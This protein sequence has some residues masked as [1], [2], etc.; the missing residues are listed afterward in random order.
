MTNLINLADRSCDQWIQMGSEGMKTPIRAKTV[1]Y[2]VTV[3]GGGMAGIC[4]AVAAA[5]NGA[6]VL[7]VQDRSVLGGN[8]SSEIRVIVHGVTKL[9]SGLPERETGILEEILLLNRFCN[10]QHSFT[11]WDHVL[12][13]FVT[14]EENLTL[15]LNTQAVRSFTEDNKIKSILLWQMSTESLITV[16]AD[17]FIDCSGDGL[18]A[19]T[20]GALYRTGR[21]GQDEFGEKYAPKEPDGWQMGATILLSSRDMGK[22]MD[23]KAPPFAIP[24]DAESTHPDRRIIPFVEG[25]WWVEVGSKDDIIGTAET[26]MHRLMGY[27]Y[28]VWDHVKNSG[29]YPEADNFALDWVGSLPGRRESRRFI[30]DYILSEPD[31]LNLKQFDD[32]VAFGGWPL[33]EHNPGGIENLA[34]PPSFWHEHFDEVYQIPFRSLY[35]RNIE[36]LLFAGRNISQ[37]HVALSS[38][39]VMGTC[40]VQGQAVGTAAALCIKHQ[41]LPRAITQ[42]YMLELQEQL[43]RDDA[44]IPQRY[45]QDSANFAATADRISASSTASGDVK[46]LVDGMSRD[47]RG[48][49]HHWKSDGLNA[50]VTFEWDKPVAIS[51]I[52]VK[53]D[54]NV[55]KNIMMLKNTRETEAYTTKIPVELLKS[56]N[57]ELLINGQWQLLAEIE[58]NQRRLIKFNFE[59]TQ[60][61][62]F[63]L[64]LLET[65]GCPDIKLFEVRCYA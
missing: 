9:K 3:V 24:F 65:Y 2:E 16:N 28:G 19:A 55:K 10:E 41:V 59:Q 53:C 17:I 60:V 35:S 58:D 48:E 34:E 52:E 20:A 12:Y 44:Y 18:M 13:D 27:A 31:Q 32:A 26:D 15:M 6:K 51:A 56:L 46:N 39:R 30:G 62:G 49:V 8:A 36:N 33:D 22:K 45:A 4:A 5:R 14:R 63:R 38:S 57:A 61:S 11:V 21:E 54:T 64:N 25:F 40:A 1:N 7:L 29:L 37:T 23:Y 42:D 47:E 50:S 43:L